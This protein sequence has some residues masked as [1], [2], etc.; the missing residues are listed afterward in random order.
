[1]NDSFQSEIE[2]YDRLLEALSKIES[3]L[4]KV[5]GRGE[6]YGELKVS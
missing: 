1:M 6:K 3:R 5:G 2:K 4:N